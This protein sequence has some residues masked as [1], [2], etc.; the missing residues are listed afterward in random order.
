MDGT[1]GLAIGRTL[2]EVQ[3][4]GGGER[5]DRRLGALTPRARSTSR[6]T[7][8][9]DDA[10]R[11]PI[12]QRRRAAMQ[13]SVEAGCASAFPFQSRLTSLSAGSTSA[14]PRLQVR[15]HAALASPP[16]LC[17]IERRRRHPQ[18]AVPPLCFDDAP[19]AFFQPPID[20][21]AAAASAS[22]AHPASVCW[23]STAPP[24][25]ASASDGGLLH[26]YS[27]PYCRWHARDQDDADAVVHGLQHILEGNGLD[28]FRLR[29][30]RGWMGMGRGRDEE[31]EALLPSNRTYATAILHLRLF[32]FFRSHSPLSFSRL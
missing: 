12:H 29:D 6:T 26:L 23:P 22:L 16:A 10:G 17:I 9:S 4:G 21:S 19:D 7:S 13:V 15:L 25:R 2:V 1:A 8:R 28:V 32:S 30:E 20:E 5:A 14:H 18:L 24:P 3:R 31:D 11:L 27:H